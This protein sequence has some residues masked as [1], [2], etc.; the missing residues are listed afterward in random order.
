MSKINIYNIQKQLHSFFTTYVLIAM[1]VFIYLLLII[2][3]PFSL[4]VQSNEALYRFSLIS[5]LVIQGDYFRLFTSMW[6]HKDVIHLISNILFLFI[7]AI[8]LEEL[9]QMK[10][11]YIVV[12]IFIA[13]GLIGNIFTF[14]FYF[15][16]ININSLGSSGGVFGRALLGGDL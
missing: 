8:R 16:Q 6:I 14:G 9:E 1:L 11:G 13:S 2:L 4:L 7:F 15:L 12:L 5:S 10:R 3:F